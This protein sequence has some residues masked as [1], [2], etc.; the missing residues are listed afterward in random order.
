MKR[1]VGLFLVIA[2]LTALSTAFAWGSSTPPSTGNT[3]TLTTT[4]VTVGFGTAGIKSSIDT[5]KCYTGIS[6]YKMSA[7]GLYLIDSDKK[8]TITLEIDYWNNTKTQWEAGPKY[9]KLLPQTN[10]KN[11][12]GVWVPSKQSASTSH[13]ASSSLYYYGIFKK[14]YTSLPMCG[15]FT[16]YK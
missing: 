1:T 2:M 9:N 14:D 5:A 10:A 3:G 7:A 6:T 13:S 16:L 11:A 12:Q 8:P 4:G 15:S